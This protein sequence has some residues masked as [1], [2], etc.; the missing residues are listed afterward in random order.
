MFDSVL[1]VCTGNICRSPV[2]ERYLRHLFPKKKIDSA[3]TRACTGLAAS[4]Q[5]KEVAARYGLSLA[6]HTGTPLTEDKLNQYD[7]ILAMEKTHIFHILSMA[8]YVRGKTFLFG[9]WIAQQNIP[10]P[11]GYDDAVF[12][13][14][15]QLIAQ[16]SQQW[17]NKLNSTLSWRNGCL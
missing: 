12:E 16:A 4:Y 6:G 7:L 3:G 10:D 9:H 11:I 15:Y 14:V 1:I 2:G 13:A 5:M 8:P 17:A